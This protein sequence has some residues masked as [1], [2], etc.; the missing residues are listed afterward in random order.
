MI[1]SH[2]LLDLT[3]FTRIAQ[4]MYIS[5]CYVGE[6]PKSLVTGIYNEIMQK[7]LPEN[8]I[9]CIIVPRL[10]SEGKA[11]SASTV[12]QAIK[13]GN[14]EALKELVPKTTLDYFMSP[15]AE[16]VV[17]RIRGEENVVHY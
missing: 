7:K 3:V 9:E 1:E 2:A 4:A 14:C 10:Q 12:R 5:R 16:A 13:D 15:Q 6:E 11:I 8:G 17:A